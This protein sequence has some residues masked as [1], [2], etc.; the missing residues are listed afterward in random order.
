MNIETSIRSFVVIPVRPDRYKYQI[1][2]G[3]EHMIDREGL[4]KLLKPV[5]PDSKIRP[6]NLLLQELKS[7]IV[8]VH[9]EDENGIEIFELRPRVTIDDTRTA[10]SKRL[11]STKTSEKLRR[12]ERKK[13]SK[14][15]FYDSELSVLQD[16]NLHGLKRES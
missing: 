1:N 13:D 15:T 2:E 3:K 7:F 8:I 14:E 16:R 12:L 9:E 5:L 11:V 4:V 6:F 10:V